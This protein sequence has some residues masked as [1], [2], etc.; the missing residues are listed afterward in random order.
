MLCFSIYNYKV[1][2]AWDEMEGR[3]NVLEEKMARLETTVLNRKWAADVEAR[4]IEAG[5]TAAKNKTKNS[6]EKGELLL[7]EM[8]ELVGEQSADKKLTAKLKLAAATGSTGG[9][10]GQNGTESI[11]ASP[12]VAELK[13]KVI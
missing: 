6:P 4:I 5:T 2:L 3:K 10:S 11:T 9:V 8:K 13:G 7:A 12:A 1:R